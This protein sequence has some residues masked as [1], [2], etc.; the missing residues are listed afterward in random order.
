MLPKRYLHRFQRFDFYCSGCIQADYRHINIISS[1]GSPYIPQKQ[2][3]QMFYD[4]NNLVTSAILIFAAAISFKN[5]AVDIRPH[6][7]ALRTST[8]AGDLGS[9]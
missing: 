8:G 2:S 9:I 6:L 1:L 3:R 7:A 5:S 4:F